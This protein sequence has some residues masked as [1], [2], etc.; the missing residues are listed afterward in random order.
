MSKALSLIEAGELGVI[1]F[2]ESTK[3]VHPL[4]EPFTSQTGAKSVFFVQPIIYRENFREIDFNVF[5]I[6]LYD[7][8]HSMKT[9]LGMPMPCTPPM[10]YF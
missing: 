4:G 3:V 1:S 5:F 6:D 7:I 10:E 2:G 8:S 9:E